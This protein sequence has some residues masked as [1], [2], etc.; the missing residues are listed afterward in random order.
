MKH[1]EKFNT[2]LSFCQCDFCFRVWSTI[3]AMSGLIF[4]TA[5]QR[6]DSTS[7]NLFQAFV[8]MVTMF[9]KANSQR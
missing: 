9:E 4:E 6:P 7:N 1:N 8:L 2:T 3:N 5:H